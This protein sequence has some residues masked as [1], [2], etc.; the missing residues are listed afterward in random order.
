MRR[1]SLPIYLWS[2]TSTGLLVLWTVG[3]PLLLHAVFLRRRIW[4]GQLGQ[5]TDG[6]G[7]ADGALAGVDDALVGQNVAARGT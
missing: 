3:R 7:F 1:H 4:G 5:A 6:C 2:S